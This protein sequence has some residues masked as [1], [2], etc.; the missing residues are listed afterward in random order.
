M[1]AATVAGEG[2]AVIWVEVA[3][4]A[5]TEA[6][7]PLAVATMVAEPTVAAITAEEHLPARMVAVAATVARLQAVA[8]VR[9]DLGPGRAIALPAAHL[10][11]GMALTEVAAP[12]A[13]RAR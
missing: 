11:A 7:A 5:S 13:A 1:A 12:Q 10:L 2:A 9:P 4:A 3:E 6:V 8:V